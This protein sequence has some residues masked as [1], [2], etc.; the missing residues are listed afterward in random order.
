MNIYTETCCSEITKASILSQFIVGKQFVNM[1]FE[2]GIFNFNFCIGRV[3]FNEYFQF[4]TF[5]LFFNISDITS[6]LLVLSNVYSNKF[7]SKV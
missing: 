2:D 4:V 5:F 3:S 1:F 7:I 6:I